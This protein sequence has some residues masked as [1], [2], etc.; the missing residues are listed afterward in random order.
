MTGNAAVSGKISRQRL[1]TIVVISMV[2]IGLMVILLDL[3]E[4]RKLIGETNWKMIPWA[5]LFTIV[6]YFCISYGFAT[7]VQLFGS[8]IKLHDIAS[9]GFISTV[10]NHLLSAGGAA[11]LSVRFLMM[12][13]KTT[14]INTILGASLFHSYFTSMGM[15]ALLPV[16]FVYILI[17][18]SLTTAV[19]TSLV[20]AIILLACLFFLASDI[21]FNAS[22]RDG[23]LRIGSRLMNKVFHRDLEEKA[24]EFSATIAMGV[25]NAGLNKRKFFLV[26]VFIITDWT[27][28]IAALWFCFS[29]FGSSLSIGVLISGFV[30]GVTAGVLS[31]IPGGLGVQEGS[32]SGIYALFGVPLSQAV[33]AAIL[34][35][36]VY[37]FVP[38]LVSIAFY[39]HRL[40]QMKENSL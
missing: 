4:V 17:H 22:L 29:A 25:K 37:Y 15:L 33:L 13:D 18:H 39:G 21:V 35:R 14:T 38:F 36:L 5:L 26:L 6:S 40:H 10:L 34:F 11:G 31:M 16:G 24:A 19:T 2:S 12:R 28:S 30:I 9:I 8:Q 32:M 27:A 23:V 20:I 1:A 7:M 3:H